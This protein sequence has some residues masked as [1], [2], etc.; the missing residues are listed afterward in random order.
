MPQTGY[1]RLSGNVAVLYLQIT[2]Y[3]T[4]HSIHSGGV[5]MLIDGNLEIRGEDLNPHPPAFGEPGEVGTSW[6]ARVCYGQSSVL[7]YSLMISW[8]FLVPLSLGKNLPAEC[9]LICVCAV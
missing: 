8:D 2:P 6:F 5:L 1:V 3:N 7:V 4:L 9:L